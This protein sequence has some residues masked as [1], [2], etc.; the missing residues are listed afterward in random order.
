MVGMGRCLLVERVGENDASIGVPDSKIWVKE[1]KGRSGVQRAK[2]E[3]KGRN[4]RPKGARRNLWW[5][6]TRVHH[7]PRVMVTSEFPNTR[8]D[9]NSNHEPSFRIPYDLL[10]VLECPFGPRK[11]W[12]AN[13]DELRGNRN[14]ARKPRKSERAKI[15]SFILCLTFLVPRNAE[16]RRGNCHNPIF[17][18]GIFSGVGTQNEVA[19]AKSAWSD[20][21]LS[22]QIT[23]E[24]GPGHI[25]QNPG[26]FDQVW[27]RLT[28]C[29]PGFDRAIPDSNEVHYAQKPSKGGLGYVSRSLESFDQVWPRF[30]QI[31]DRIKS[32]IEL[33]AP[34][35]FWRAWRE[36]RFGTLRAENG[37]ETRELWPNLWK[38]VQHLAKFC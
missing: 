6:L 18:R 30:D 7:A 12:H 23:P 36:L 27:P 25:S 16:Q 9:A 17:S 5:D 11:G 22:R 3:R 14:Q 34:W 29:W 28:E 32:W 31:V 37:R 4:E 38:T 24:H 20:K 19:R 35:P 13:R 21:S 8:P 2:R 1:Q 10:Q 33:T 15:E 26:S